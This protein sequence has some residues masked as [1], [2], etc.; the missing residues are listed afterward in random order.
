MQLHPSLLILVFSFF[1][2]CP[3][4][5]GKR[6]TDFPDAT[7]ILG[8]PDFVTI[9][10]GGTVNATSLSSPWGIAVDPATGKVFVADFLN[11]RVLRFA[12]FAALTNGAAAEAVLGQPDFTSN[13]PG[14]SPSA[15]DSPQ[16]VFVDGAGRLWVADSGNARILRF[17]GASTLGDFPAANAVL[18]QPDFVSNAMVTSIN[19]LRLPRGLALDAAGNLFVTDVTANRVLLFAAAATLANGANASLVLGQGNFTNLSAATS[20]SRMSSPNSLVLDGAGN[21]Y[22]ADR[23]NHRVLRYD[24]AAA[25]TNGANADGVFGQIDFLTKVTS[26]SAT[27][28]NGPIDL[29]LDPDGLLWVAEFTNTRVIGFE[30][31]ASVGTGA[32]PVRVIGQADF[33]TNI[34]AA[35]V[36]R[37]GAP[38][39]LA[40]DGLG[41]LYVTDFA[42][43][44]VLTFEKDH[45]L[46]DFTIGEKIG[47]QRGANVYNRTGAGQKKPVKTKGKEVKFVGV[48]GN[49]GNI[50][51]TYLV[52]SDRT[53][54]RFTIKVFALTGGK[55][56]I[57]AGAKIGTHQ[58]GTILA[59]GAQTFEMRVRAK[60]KFREKRATNKTWIEAASTTDGELDRVIGEV[61]NRP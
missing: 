32:T 42:A 53:N 5:A 36:N 12:S 55:R 1:F 17:D 21:L 29:R 19:G 23:G 9:A 24:N 6:W 11:H 49:D 39:G 46:P 4:H 14:L 34:S 15:F 38:A 30:D 22:V 47:S 18:G 43:H 51:D 37:F 27:G 56:N 13:T 48:L 20:Q 45:H 58:S 31:P 40:L 16:G 25:L 50:P 59:G 8:Q 44:R 33:T 3:L 57:T 10:P 26:T 52:R 60:S 41:R 7:R 2:S 61:K 35:A 28:M 54:A